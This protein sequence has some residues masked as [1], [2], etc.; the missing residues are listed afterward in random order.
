MVN[1]MLT[2]SAFTLDS[3]HSRA[4]LSANGILQPF[5]LRLR[6][7]TNNYAV[8]SAISYR[9]GMRKFG[10]DIPGIPGTQSSTISALTTLFEQAG[11]EEIDTRSIEVTHSFAD[12]DAFWKAQTPSY[13]PATKMIAAMP[14]GDR[15]KLMETVRAGLPVSADGKIQYCARANA[16]K[17]RTHIT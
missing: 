4:A 16:I 13:S 8:L 3:P 5:V 10:M 14:D 17:A 11:F 9:A 12:F 7:S 1:A 15:K 2:G 6:R